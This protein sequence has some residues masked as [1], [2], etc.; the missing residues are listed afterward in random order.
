MGYYSNIDDKDAAKK[1][2]Q[3]LTSLRAPQETIDARLSVLEASKVLEAKQELGI[4]PV[5]DPAPK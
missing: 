2:I 1:I 5:S 3:F 4:V